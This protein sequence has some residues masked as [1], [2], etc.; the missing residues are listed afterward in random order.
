MYAE[1]GSLER[2]YF[3]GGPPR[4][5]KSILAYSL[6]KKIGGHVVSTD[7]IR[8]AAKKACSDKESDYFIINR[9]EHVPDAE[10]IENHGVYPERT[11][12][13]QNRES[14]AIWESVVSFCNT[15]VEDDVIHVVEGVALLPSLVSTMKNKPKHILYVGNTNED[16]LASIIRYGE[17]FPHQDW[18]AGMGYSKEKVEA[19]AVFVRA[20]SEYFKTEAEKHGFPYFEISDDNFKKSIEN[21]IETL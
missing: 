21:I 3:I 9:T 10:W 15:F 18:I 14:K 4:V 13:A 12:E 19:F 7:S 1:N 16:H 2:T 8:N 11:I 5:G 17:E 20:M 6:A